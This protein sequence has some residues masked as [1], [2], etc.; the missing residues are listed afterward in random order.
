[1]SAAKCILVINITHLPPGLLQLAV[2]WHLWRTDE[3]AAVSSERRRPSGYWHPMLR[4]HIA[5][6]LSATLATSTPA[7]RL[8]GGYSR[9]PVAVWHFTTVPGRQLSSCR[10]C[11]WAA[12]AFHSEPN[13]RSDADIQHLWRQSVRSCRPWTME[14]SS[15]APERRWHIVQRISAVTKDISVWTVGPRRSVNCI[16]C[17]D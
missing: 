16:N 15:V 6:A 2:L 9:T 11:S 13:M 14:Q 12:T 8:Q 7:R 17:A 4:P 5:G 10:R 1:M 3:L